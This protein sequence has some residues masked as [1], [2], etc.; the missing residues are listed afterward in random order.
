MPPRSRGDPQKSAYLS[1]GRRPDH[2][3]KRWVRPGPVS[4]LRAP[5]RTL[6]ARRWSLPIVAEPRALVKVVGDQVLASAPD[7]VLVEEGDGLKAVRSTPPPGSTAPLAR[8]RPGSMA[9]ARERG[10]AGPRVVGPAV[11]GLPRRTPTGAREAGAACSSLRAAT[12]GICGRGVSRMHLPGRSRARSG[13]LEHGRPMLP[14]SRPLSA[15]FAWPLN[16]GGLR[17]RLRLRYRGLPGEAREEL[18]QGRAVCAVVEGGFAQPP[19]LAADGCCRLR[20]VESLDQLLSV[21][22]GVSGRGDQSVHAVVEVPRGPRPRR[23]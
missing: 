6:P 18:A 22:R 21:G 14:V 15:D 4:G 19:A 11:S 17:P 1:P 23:S 13:G 9:R 10:G 3:S 7:V 20:A 5:G 16:S 12:S 8:G 2:S